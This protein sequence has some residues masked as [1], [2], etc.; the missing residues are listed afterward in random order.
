[1]ICYLEGNLLGDFIRDSYEA[2]RLKND[3]LKGKEQKHR[4]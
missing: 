2:T 4:P 1:M 3:E